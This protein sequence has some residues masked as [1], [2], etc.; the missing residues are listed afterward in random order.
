MRYFVFDLDETLVEIYPICYF[1]ASLRIMVDEDRSH[2]LYVPK[3]FQQTLEKAYRF[4]VHEVLQQEKGS[5]PLGLLR[6][7]IL[8][9]MK[10]LQR[11]KQEGLIDGIM[12]YS[13]NPHLHN[14]EFVADMIHEHVKS[15]QLTQ[16]CIHLHHELRQEERALHTRL[17]HKTWNGVKHSLIHGKN[18]R[19]PR[20]LSPHDV[21]FFDDLDHMDLQKV[22]GDHYIKVPP[23]AHHASFDRLAA[24]YR[25]AL[26]DAGVD[27]SLFVA[28]VCDLL[29]LRI[30][31][32]IAEEPTLDDLIQWFRWEM[33]ETPSILPEEEFVKQPTQQEEGI[34]QMWAV[35]HSIQ[36]SS[37]KMRAVRRY[38]KRQPT[39]KMRRRTIRK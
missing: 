18:S 25:K 29:H 13:N 11:L 21:Y 17:I 4:Y 16:E 3:H 19:A 33:D 38:R 28:L 15:T 9:V 32:Y 2:L 20:T 39:R 37:M 30:P 1:I 14:L 6:P 24:L 10:E 27:R 36:P 34:A 23:Y 31:K 7:G 8:E 35:I 26:N 5:N 22:L 12:I